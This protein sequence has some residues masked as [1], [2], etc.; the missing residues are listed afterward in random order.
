MGATGPQ[1]S[2]ANKDCEA[3]KISESENGRHHNLY[4]KQLWCGVKKSQCIY[5]YYSVDYRHNYIGKL[6]FV[7]IAICEGATGGYSFNLFYT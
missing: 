1:G 7:S 2:K 6:Q 3:Y 5:V 4:Q